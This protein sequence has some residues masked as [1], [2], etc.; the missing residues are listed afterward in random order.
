[1]EP[2]ITY[3]SIFMSMILACMCGLLNMPSS[4]QRSWL[5]HKIVSDKLLN[6]TDVWDLCCRLM[7]V[8]LEDVKRRVTGITHHNNIQRW[9]QVLTMRDLSTF[10]DF[11]VGCDEDMICVRNTSPIGG[12]MVRFGWNVFI[13]KFD[14]QNL[15]M[16]DYICCYLDEWKHI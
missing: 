1:M 10:V 7:L 13:W 15:M 16:Y 2:T 4:D 8:R 6:E 14:V 9:R 5:L 11:C 3:C 12:M